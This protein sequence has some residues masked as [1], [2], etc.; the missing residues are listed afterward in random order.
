MHTGDSVPLAVQGTPM[1]ACLLTMTESGFGCVG[2]TDQAGNLVG[3]ITDGDLRRHMSPDLLGK[4]A[5]EVMSSNPKTVP[6][7][8]LAGEVLLRMETEKI[9]AV[10]VMEGK[11]PVGFVRLLDLLSHKV[12]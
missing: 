6:T 8:A 1:S 4:P 5:E 3:V 2:I 10:F 12:A 9:S 7:G 11:T